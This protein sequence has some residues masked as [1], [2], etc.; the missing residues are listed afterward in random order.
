MTIVMLL[1]LI[2]LF[3]LIIFFKFFW[4]RSIVWKNTPFVHIRNYITWV[5]GC[6][7]TCFFEVEKQFVWNSNIP[8]NRKAVWN[9]EKFIFFM[10]FYFLMSENTL[11]I[12]GNN[13]WIRFWKLRGGKG[14]RNNFFSQS[15]LLKPSKTNCIWRRLS[16]LVLIVWWA[17]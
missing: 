17:S 3:F 14:G 11:K 16:N 4:M 10:L 12:K 13:W 6:I 7:L 9:R 5:N 2:R 8:I 1:N 15:V